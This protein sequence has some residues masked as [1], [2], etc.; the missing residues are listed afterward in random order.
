MLTAG[1]VVQKSLFRVLY[2]DVTHVYSSTKAQFVK[3]AN[4]KL[5]NEQTD[6]KSTP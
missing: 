3:S 4:G 1:V 5:Q 2:S 6:L